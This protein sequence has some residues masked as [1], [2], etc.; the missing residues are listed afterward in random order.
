MLNLLKAEFH[1][2][3]T[4]KMFYI[5]L[6]LNLFQAMVV[7]ASL[8]KFRMTSGKES[9]V[10]I[11]GIQTGLAT[12]ILIGIFASDFI[13]T[14]FTSGYIKNLISYGHKRINVFLSKA[15]V[16]YIGI[17]IISCIA[18]LSIAA[19]NT[20][21]NGYGEVFAFSS[22]ISLI[23]LL[24]LMSLISI[25]IG[26]ISVL[27]AFASRNVN[28][29]ICIIAA[30]DFI[31][32]IFDIASI[33]NPALQFIYNS[34]IFSQPKLVLSGKAGTPQFLHAAFVSLITIF[35]TTYFSI[36]IF[37]KADIK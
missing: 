37:K 23:M 25:A 20:A 15:M 6:L 26:S 13:V 12:D 4:S 17:V 33:H 34:I 21:S 18:P 35:I 28:F 16:Y 3:K 30:V 27:A 10:W 8:K 9:L 31:Y 19:I 22:L 24:L 5:I 7:Y 14:E 29:T 2:L 11:F 1:K 32:R 36:Y